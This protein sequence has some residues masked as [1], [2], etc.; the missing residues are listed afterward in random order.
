MKVYR[1]RFD[2]NKKKDLLIRK[3]RS[4][5]CS[6]NQNKSG[7]SFFKSYKKQDVG[8]CLVINFR[9]FFL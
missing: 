9:T 6:I 2:H 3:R 7:N 4:F 1:M 8:W 5:V